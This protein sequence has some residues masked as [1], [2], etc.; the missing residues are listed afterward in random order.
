MLDN[1]PFEQPKTPQKPTI[2]FSSEAALPDWS[3]FQHGSY[4]ARVDWP[5]V[6]VVV[7]LPDGARRES[8]DFWRDS[9]LSA[10]DKA[11]VEGNPVTEVIEWPKPVLWRDSL[12]R[13]VDVEDIDKL[14]ALN[15]LMMHVTRM[16]KVGWHAA[17]F[18]HDE[19]TQKLRETVLY[20]RKPNQADN[21]R[22]MEYNRLNREVGKS[23][24]API[25]IPGDPDALQTDN[26]EPDAGQGFDEILNGIFRPKRSPASWA[27]IESFRD[28]HK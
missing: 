4:L 21:E 8:A 20:G 27:T 17:N 24:R 6:S 12:G 23:F 2:T 28:A 16:A 18:K 1:N 9:V 5:L 15:I 3:A 13:A 7:K 14:Y 25:Q 11:V 26:I 10:A 22:A 19:L